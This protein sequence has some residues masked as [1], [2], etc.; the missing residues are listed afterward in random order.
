MTNT[1]HGSCLCGAI[2]YEVEASED[3]WK[4]VCSPTLR[5]VFKR[6][7]GSPMRTD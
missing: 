5:V 7:R 1:L 3:A 2:N 6:A 4:K